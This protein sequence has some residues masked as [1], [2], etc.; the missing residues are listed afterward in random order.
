M[1]CSIQ[2]I[3]AKEYKFEWDIVGH[4][5]WLVPCELDITPIDHHGAQALLVCMNDISERRLHENKIRRLV[6]K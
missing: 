6:F 5:G 4:L 1:I 2:R 3:T